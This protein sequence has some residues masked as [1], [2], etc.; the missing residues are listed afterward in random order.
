MSR[1]LDVVI[2]TNAATIRVLEG[3]QKK[4][5]RMTAED[6]AKYRLDDCLGGNSPTIHQRALRRI[7]GDKVVRRPQRSWHAPTHHTPPRNTTPLHTYIHHDYHTT[8]PPHTTTTPH[9]ASPHH[10]YTQHITL[11][12]STL[13]KAHLLYTSCVQKLSYLLYG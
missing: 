7:Y 9:L 5:T 8:P 6:A 4:L 12:A 11:S 10:Y 1:Q 3:V 2:E 13:R